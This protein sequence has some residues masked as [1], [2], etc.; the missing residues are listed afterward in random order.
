M[1]RVFS[2]AIQ[3]GF[4]F[5]DQSKSLAGAAGVLLACVFVVSS[6]F[7]A[8]PDGEV[9]MEDVKFQDL[10]LDNADGVGALYKRIQAAAKHVCAVHGATRDSRA[11]S[12]SAKCTKDAGARAIE[13]INLPALTELVAK[14][15]THTG[16]GRE[17][18]PAPRHLAFVNVGLRRA[19]TLCL[20]SSERSPL[21]HGRIGSAVRSI[22]VCVCSLTSNIGTSSWFAIGVTLPFLE[23][24]FQ[25]FPSYQSQCAARQY[26]PTDG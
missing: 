8:E 6:V 7:A 25:S 20:Y 26:V 18:T 2:L 24:R 19:H 21:L 4:Q 23:I 12:A 16:S 14:A 9:R 17:R 10:N 22:L 1:V 3:L 15:E 5:M 11:A 13:K